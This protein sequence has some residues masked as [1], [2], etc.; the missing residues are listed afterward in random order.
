MAEDILY[1]SN[2]RESLA[3]LEDMR[4]VLHFE[5]VN[6]AFL[7]LEVKVVSRGKSSQAVSLLQ[8]SSPELR[9]RAVST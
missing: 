2:A 3:P 5:L 1:S 4:G 9:Q 7:A 8:V 6:S